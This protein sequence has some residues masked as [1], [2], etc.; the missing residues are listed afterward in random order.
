MSPTFIPG[1]E[2][3]RRF[4]GE[5]VLPIL[6]RHHPGLPHAAARIGWGSDVLGFDTEMSTDHGWGPIVEMFVRDQDSTL[7]DSIDELMM[8][9]LPEEFLGY[10]VR[11]PEPDGSGPLRHWVQLSTVRR[12]WHDWLGFDIDQPPA[13]ADWLTFPSQRLGTLTGGAVHHDGFGELS[14]LREQLSYYP[15][16]VW[17]YL[18]AAGWQRIGQEEHL[19]PRAGFAGDELGSSLIGSRLVREVMRQAFLQ[20]RRYAP[21]AKWL[22]TAFAR[23]TA[24]TELDPPLRRVQRA[25]SWQQRNAAIGEAL[26]ALARRHNALGVTTSVNEQL[27]DFFGRPFRRISGSD[28]ASVTLAAIA[29]PAIR[30]LGEGRIIGGV[31][32]FTDSTDLLEAIQLRPVLRGLY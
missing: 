32:Q 22:G 8:R 16:D 5:A 29:D 10:P 12:Y 13:T 24:A 17:L 27:T 2:L 4:Y 14:S 9:E 18:T 23:L 21:Y 6:D 20:E 7:I 11:F 15:D 25:Q 3:S 19:M 28:I 26:E 1:L 30:A 31:D